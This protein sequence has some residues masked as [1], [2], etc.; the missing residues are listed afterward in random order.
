MHTCTEEGT[1]ILTCTEEV[2]KMAAKY[3]QNKMRFWVNP[4]LVHIN[5]TA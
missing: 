2:T 3:L 4:A 5:M 1:N